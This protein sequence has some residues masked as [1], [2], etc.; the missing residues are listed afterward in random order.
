MTMAMARI[1]AE[2]A[3]LAATNEPRTMRII[4]I[5]M[6]IPNR[7]AAY[8]SL[9]GLVII[10]TTTITPRSKFHLRPVSRTR[11]LRMQTS[12]YPHQPEA[13]SRTFTQFITKSPLAR[14][15]ATT[16]RLPARKLSHRPLSL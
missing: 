14:H 8:H 10:I 5:S 1:A 12:R 13:S 11:H 6:F 3:P 2:P 9:T 15:P 4:T 16:R 7:L